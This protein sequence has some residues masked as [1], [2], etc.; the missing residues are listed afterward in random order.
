MRPPHPRGC[1][2]LCFRCT[3]ASVKV[4]GAGAPGSKRQRFC[5]G[6]AAE[7]DII[8][9]D[10]AR[11]RSC[12]LTDASLPSGNSQMSVAASGTSDTRVLLQVAPPSGRMFLRLLCSVDVK[13][14]PAIFCG[15]FTCRSG[16]TSLLAVQGQ[17]MWHAAGARKSENDG[18]S[19]LRMRTWLAESIWRS[20]RIARYSVCL[21]HLPRG[22]S[23]GQ[24]PLVW[25]LLGVQRSAR[26][27][28]LVQ[29]TCELEKRHFS[30]CRQ[31][32][33]N[34]LRYSQS[35]D[36]SLIHWS[37]A[38]ANWSREDN[39]LEARLSGERAVFR[40]YLQSADTCGQSKARRSRELQHMGIRSRE[41]EQSVPFEGCG[42]SPGDSIMRGRP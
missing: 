9:T 7:F 19:P 22:A 35:V 26:G 3:L 6:S 28:S 12:S 15:R 14:W 2:F 41:N 42:V 39:L 24:N 27:R 40:V 4:C 21:R 37:Q 8:F 5:G 34:A 10:S 31:G 18:T 32:P 16:E 13:H 17:T 29:Q 33:V 30:A 36:W 20:C 11:S 1:A 23:K 25:L 38:G